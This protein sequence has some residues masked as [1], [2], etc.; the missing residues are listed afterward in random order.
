MNIITSRIAYKNIIECGKASNQKRQIIRTLLSDKEP[1]SRREIASETLIE[2]G[3]V[4]G[5]VNSLIKLGIVEETKM[6]KCSISRKL[7]KPVQLVEGL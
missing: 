6:R 7:I 3:S 4:S 5:R 1:M 2:L